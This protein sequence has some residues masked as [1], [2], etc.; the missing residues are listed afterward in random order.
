MATETIVFLLERTPETT[1]KGPTA[2]LTK[3]CQV[4][5]QYYVLHNI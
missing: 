5:V 2:D 1:G 4:E 3:Q